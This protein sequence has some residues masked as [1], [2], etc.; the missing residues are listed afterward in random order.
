M[1]GRNAHSFP[2]SAWERTA[3][4]ALRRERVERGRANVHL[5][6]PIRFEPYLRTMVWG[7]RGLE[8]LGK[9]LTSP[10]SYGEAWE[11]SDH[12]HHHSVVAAGPAKGQTLRQL[13]EH[14]RGEL[15]G[16]AAARYT[17]FSWLV[18]FLDA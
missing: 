4:A 2:R 3:Q 11:L 17:Q 1:N 15:L 13:M 18:K 8:T 7:G 14:H 6:G 9:R 10:E 16:E 12:P 5:D